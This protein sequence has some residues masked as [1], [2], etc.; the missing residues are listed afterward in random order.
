MIVRRCVC[1]CWGQFTSHRPKGRMPSP[2]MSDNPLQ[3]VVE[4]LAA[5]VGIVERPSNQRPDQGLEMHPIHRA[6]A[7]VASASSQRPEMD[8]IAPA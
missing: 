2:G 4:D 7:G 8:L 3:K 1:R 5:P 6:L